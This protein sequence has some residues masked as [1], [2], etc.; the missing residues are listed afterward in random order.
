MTEYFIKKL[1]SRLY[2]VA[3]FEIEKRDIERGKRC[4]NK[5]FTKN[6]PDNQ[7]YSLK[8]FIL[9][10]ECWKRWDSLFSNTYP[11]I[12]EKSGKLKKIFP[13]NDILI[14]NYKNMT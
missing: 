10:L 2:L 5:Y 6:T 7:D 12:K 11:K 1:L 14:D 8:F 13:V 3:S 4:L 9:L